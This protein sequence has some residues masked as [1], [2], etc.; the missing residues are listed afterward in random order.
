MMA[1]STDLTHQ[2][3]RMASKI[4]EDSGKYPLYSLLLKATATPYA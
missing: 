2:G 3:Q 4:A 1:G